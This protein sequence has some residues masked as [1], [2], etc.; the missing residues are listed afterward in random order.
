MNLPTTEET[1][2]LADELHSLQELY[3]KGALPVSSQIQF[4][5]AC[6]F[7]RAVQT[8]KKRVEN[9]YAPVK[10][11]RFQQHRE[12]TAAEKVLLGPID[13]LVQNLDAALLA[14]ADAARARMEDLGLVDEADL[15]DEAAFTAGAGALAD[16]LPRIR[17]VSIKEKWR[18]EVSSIEDL[19]KAA[20]RGEVPLSWLMPN[21][22]EID[23]AAESY[24]ERLSE[25]D[26]IIAVRTPS[27][28]ARAY[29]AKENA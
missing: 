27:I 25:F 5:A 19:V 2:R 16:Q 8:L 12:A 24:Q 11:E 26:G 6:L 28:V 22:K 14:Y 4:R 1:A 7:R 10:R 9:I 17:G 13:E 15:D 3:T 23:A 18:G 20:A 21:Q 29:S